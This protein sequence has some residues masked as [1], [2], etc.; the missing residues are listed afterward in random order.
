MGVVLVQTQIN[1]AT[2]GSSI[3]ALAIPELG[4][5]AEGN[6]VEGDTEPCAI[7]AA[8]LTRPADSLAPEGIN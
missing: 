3:L 5:A 6:A 8:W 1:E 4:G 2:P 7:V